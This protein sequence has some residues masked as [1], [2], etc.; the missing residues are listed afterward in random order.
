VRSGA[1]LLV[2]VAYAAMCAIWGTTWYAIVLALSGF[3]PLAGA[4]VRFLIAGGVFG[5]VALAVRRRDGSAPPLHLILTLAIA[6]FGVNYALTYYAEQHLASGLVAVLFGTM[7]FFIFALAALTLHERA[8]ARV[9]GGATV[10]LAGV[11]TIS[12]TGDR[13]DLL[14]VGAA[15]GATL[16]SA[17]GNVALKRHAASDPLR[18]LPPAMLLAGAGNLI[19]GTLTERIDWHAALAPVP[20]LATC[21]LAVAGSAIAFYLNHWLLQRLSKGVVGLSALIVPV[22]A[23]IV[24]VLIGHEAFGPRELIGA[25]LVV[26]GMALALAPLPR[27]ELRATSSS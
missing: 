19:A 15:L 12:L 7:P 3:P 26:A 10:A 18:T 4:G 6:F 5:I 25:A 27:P 14:A 16:L 13:G 24:G 9:I 8:G 22:I 11:A 20:L 1:N 17:I 23:V 2:I 21:Y